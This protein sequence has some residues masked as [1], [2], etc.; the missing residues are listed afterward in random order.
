[1]IEISEDDEPCDDRTIVFLL[2]HKL[3]R[4]CSISLSQS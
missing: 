4:F 2:K 3:M 1:M